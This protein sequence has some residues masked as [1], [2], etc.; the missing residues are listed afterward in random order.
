M[1]NNFRTVSNRD[2]MLKSILLE[3]KYLEAH[4]FY[5]QMLVFSS[6]ATSRKRYIGNVFSDLSSRLDDNI[7][8]CCGLYPGILQYLEISLNFD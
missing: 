7:V 6:P 3:S 5:K 2:K 1:K 8:E 4:F